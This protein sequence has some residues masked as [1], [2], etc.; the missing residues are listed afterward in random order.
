MKEVLLYGAYL[1][2]F[3]GKV[4]EEVQLWRNL[5]TVLHNQYGKNEE[6]MEIVSVYCALGA[7][8][9]V[10]GKIDETVKMYERSIKMNQT[11]YGE[12]C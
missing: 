1:L 11:I 7:P 8:V 5:L 10:S 4:Q 6:N 9:G 3:L 2:R 12:E